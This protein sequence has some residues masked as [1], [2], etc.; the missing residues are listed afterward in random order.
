MTHV[1]FP[2][3]CATAM[4]VFAGIIAA[5]ARLLVGA[6]PAA[7]LHRTFLDGRGS[8][9]SSPQASCTRLSSAASSP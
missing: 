4:L 7:L 8:A 3:V 2:I 9:A 1:V 5:R 6:R